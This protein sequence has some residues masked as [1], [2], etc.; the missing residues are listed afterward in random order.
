MI[1]A[2]R[3]RLAD[4]DRNRQHG[5]LGADV[6]VDL[7]LGAFGAGQVDVDLGIVDA[8]RV[9]VELGAAGAPAEALHLRNG[10]DQPLG[11]RAQTVEL[12]ERDAGVVLKVDEN[13][14]FV[15]RRQE[16]AREQVGAEPSGQHAER[17][18]GKQRS[19]M[20]ERPMQQLGV[21]G[22]KRAYE[23]AVSAPVSLS[24]PPG[25]RR[26]ARASR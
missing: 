19:R 17:D 13:G 12:G 11:N 6:R 1:E 14:A 3:D 24:A 20:P 16:R 23:E 7:L 2:V 9:L 15:E 18:C 26:R 25:N 10:H 22:L 5:E 4:G 21:A 8:F